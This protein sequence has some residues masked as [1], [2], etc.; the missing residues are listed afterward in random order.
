MKTMKAMKTFVAAMLLITG[1]SYA[2]AALG[3]TASD[4]TDSSSAGAAPSSPW[5]TSRGSRQTFT[6]EQASRPEPIIFL[7]MR[8]MMSA[9]IDTSVKLREDI[10]RWRVYTHDRKRKVDTNWLTPDDFKRRREQYIKLL[11]E[12]QASEKKNTVSTGFNSN[13]NINTPEAEKLKLQARNR[14]LEKAKFAA[15]VWADPLLRDYLLGLADLQ[16]E[17]NIPRQAHT[18]LGNDVAEAPRVAGLRQAYGMT[19]MRLNLP[20]EALPQFIQGLQLQPDSR[21]LLDL[22]KN[23]MKKTP[24]AD[25]KKPIFLEAQKL[26]NR[27][28]DTA[29]PSGFSSSST[30][31]SWVM[32]GRPWPNREADL[33]PT[34]PY[35]RLVFQQAVAIP[36][37][38][39][40]L[41]VDAAAVDKAED[42]LVQL[43]A[44]TLVPGKVKNVSSFGKAAPLPLAIITIT[45][46][47][48]T[49]ITGD[50]DTTFAPNA[51]VTFYGLNFY[52]EM[53]STVREVKAKI[54]TIATDGTTKL[55]SNLV[56]GEAAGPVI[57][58]DGQL[59][60]FLAGK[61]DAMAEDGGPN[62][63]YTLKEMLPLL[64]Q[65]RKASPSFSS[66]SFNSV[67]RTP[68][69]QPAPAKTFIVHIIASEKFDK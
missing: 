9:S 14:Q 41:L 64:D 16:A 63:L 18:L 65:A 33:L 47:E 17:G 4:S 36:V 26:A 52:E 31:P 58:A 35:D 21:E 62:K 51:P 30:L 25:I 56:P 45:D 10:E 15:R 34:P 68:S 37:G 38:K 32:P 43:D 12:A 49:P 60:G 2:P 29:T 42:V 27:Y 55:T 6:A 1:L 48:L 67:K 3:A 61:I 40:T 24:G 5:G 54:K 13:L 7:F 8:N 59:V 28:K 44:K 20:L 66:G 46:G 39:K 50:K 57:A 19:L 22:L 69:T 11:R 53:G 23:A